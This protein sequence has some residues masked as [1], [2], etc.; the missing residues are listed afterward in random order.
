MITKRLLPLFTALGG[1]L[2]P[3][4]ALALAVGMTPRITQAATLV[5]TSAADNG[6][7]TLRQALTN[8]NIGDTITFSPTVFPAGSPATIFVL[9]AL[10]SLTLNN[11]IIDASNA[12]VILNG[13][14]APANTPG[15]VISADG[16]AIRGLTIQQFSG[17]GIFVGPGASG[18]TIGGDRSVGGGPNG[19]GNRIAANGGRGIEIQGVGANGNFVLGNYIG[20]DASGQFDQGNT[21]T[22]VAIGFGAQNNTIGGALSGYRNVI[23]GNNENGVWIGS[24]GANQNVVIG[25]YIG[26]TADGLGPVGN[27]FSGVSLQGGAQNNQIGGGAPGEGNLISGNGHNGI[28]ISDTGTNGNMVLG[29]LIGPDRFGTNYIGQVQNGI[30]INLGASNNAIGDGTVGGRNLISRNALDGILIADSNTQSNTVQ[31]NYIGSNM[32]G[33]AALPNGQHGVEI[34]NGAHN[35]LVGGNRLSGQGNLLSGNNNHGLVVT[36]GAHHNTAAGNIVGPDASGSY[37]LGN[38]PSGG[39]DIAE[40]AYDNIIGGLGAGE[41]NLISGNQLDGIALFSSVTTQTTDNQVLGNLIGLTLTGT[42]ALPNAGPGVFNVVGAVRTRIEGNT[43]SGNQTQGVRLS[44]Q[45]AMSSTVTANRIGM[46]ISGSAPIPNGSYGIWITENSHGHVLEDNLVRSNG[47][48]G[49]KVEDLVSG[50]TPYS[51]TIGP[52]NQVALNAGYGIS[53]QGC[54][55]NAIT[56]NSI[57]SHTLAG[58]QS[59]CPSA[60]QLSLVTTATVT[61]TAMANARIE[62]FTDDDEEGRVFEGVVFADAL[63]VFTFT[64]PGGLNGPNVTATSTDANGNTSG[65]SQP[66]HVFWTLLLYFNGDN[67]LDTSFFDTLDH[68]VAAGPSPRANVLVLIDGY[69]RTL[70]NTTTYSGTMLYDVT[71]GQATVLTTTLGTTLTVPGELNLGDPQTLAD[72]ITWGRAY[73]PARYTLLS[74]V[75]HGGGWAPSSSSV[76]TGGLPVRSQDWLAGNSGLSWDFT[77][78]YDHLDIQEIEQVLSTTTTSGANPVD[79]V[80]FDVCLMGMIEVAYQIQDYATYFVSSQN[81]GW[82]PDGPAGRYVQTIHGLGA[83][84][85]PREMAGLLVQAYANSMP[86]NGH[87]FT[88]A[89]VDLTRLLT[90]TTAVDSL[91]LAISQTLSLPGQTALLFEVYSVTQKIDY[92]SDLSIEPTTDSF[93]DLYDF[94]LRTSQQ[95]T[96][97]VILAASNAVT[98]ALSQALVAEQHRSDTPWFPES[99][100]WDLDNTHGLS[101]YLPLGEDMELVIT[102]TSPIS[103]GVVITSIVP[104][105]NLYTSDQLHFVADTRWGGLINAYYE[106]SPTLT[107][108][109][110]GPLTSLLQPDVTPPQTMVTV[111][112]QFSVEQP[113]TITWASTDTQNSVVSATLWHQPPGAG[114]AS[115]GLTQ[116]GVGGVFAFTLTEPCLNHFAVLAVDEPGNLELP[117]HLTNTATVFANRCRQNQSGDPG[118][119]TIYEL[120]LTNPGEQT[121]IFDINVSGNTWATSAPATAGPLASGASLFVTI[122]VNVPPHVIAGTID[123]AMI[124]FTAQGGGLQPLIFELITEANPHK[125]FLPFLGR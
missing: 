49:I 124:V 107:D 31:G 38:H 76:I 52:G 37:S 108:T 69:T 98:T 40:G 2:I 121:A 70:T 66:V 14:S 11:L 111:T 88:I 116:T 26:T 93:V 18:N 117:D 15:L 115:T 62:I 8:A 91:G 53:I 50:Q 106:L 24:S 36:R 4:L 9:S 95:F 12:G 83:S 123:T 44:G 73:H 64:Q 42:A 7:G 80:F 86:P 6:P 113:I 41:G 110:G 72:F 57:Y 122:T 22:G 85:G 28:Y 71:R 74:I 63:G 112:G 54:G 35:N 48:D 30:V 97:P 34:T 96:H 79:V 16:C 5:V 100:F 125:R 118:Q 13:V 17:N 3:I 90:V 114:W 94:A 59:V 43:I 46:D 32:D 81:I 105:R 25:N 21:Y 39:I 23:S 77:S 89:A 103:P 99:Q 87:P 55:G 65:F 10:P 27:S 45:T 58:I 78:D 119:L 19:Q 67:D 102:A 109:I 68:I 29:N 60:P 84:M 101:I 75:D 120:E 82:A 1:G 47:A 92:D 51:N 61:G 56:Q 104:L 20:L 33:S